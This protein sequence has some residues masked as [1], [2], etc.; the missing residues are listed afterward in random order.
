MKS[1]SA[2][3]S[4]LKLSRDELDLHLQ[5]LSEEH[6]RYC[7]PAELGSDWFD[8]FP[9]ETL[10]E[11]LDDDVGLERTKYS[12]HDMHH[13][14]A[15]KRALIDKRE[16]LESKDSELLVANIDSLLEKIKSI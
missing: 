6:D 15:I 1:R 10:M 13:R 16:E 12:L 3:A 11:S 4:Q 8:C 7:L 14:F 5:A 2:E 9:I